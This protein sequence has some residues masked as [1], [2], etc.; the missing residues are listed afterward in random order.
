MFITGK[1]HSK[2]TEIIELSSYTASQ[3]RMKSQ[4]EPISST[5]ADLRRFAERSRARELGYEI[6]LN[7][8]E[9]A[10]YVGLHPKTTEKMARLGEIPAH[11]VC[12]V[13][14]KTW[15]Y[16][17]S[18]LDAWLRAKVDSPRHPCSPNGKDAKQ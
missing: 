14:R 15:K 5:A 8:R 12:G 1:A 7:T 13:R 9:A 17:P 2:I 6:P 3:R 11:A 16:Y 4:R 18:E 10:E